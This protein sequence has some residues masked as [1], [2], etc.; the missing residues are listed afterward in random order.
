[1]RF[2]QRLTLLSAL[3]LSITAPAFAA[4]VAWQGWDSG[5]ASA[6]AS[7]RYI[8]VD[9]YTNWCGWCKRMDK[10]VYARADVSAY[11]NQHFTSVKLNAESNQV[12]H[13]EGEERTARGIASGFRVNS[14]PTTVFL[15]HDGEHLTNVPGYIPADRFLQLLRYIGDGHM[16]QGV[17]WADYVAKSAKP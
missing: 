16:E 17:R 11:L 10:D 8:L 1:M 15:S 13:Y 12:L 4:E 5:L 2:V 7:K 3:L 14:Y 9:V 6:K